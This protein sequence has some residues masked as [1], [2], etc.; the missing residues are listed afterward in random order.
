MEQRG[1]REEDLGQDMFN[2]N[3]KR[4]AI[5]E[6]QRLTK[7]RR[8]LQHYEQHKRYKQSRTTGG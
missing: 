1:K 3:D 2:M 7:T 5:C 4:A 8:H 6:T